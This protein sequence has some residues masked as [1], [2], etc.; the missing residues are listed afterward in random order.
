MTGPDFLLMLEEKR[1]RIIK[2]QESQNGGGLTVIIEQRAEK[3]TP[4]DS[5]N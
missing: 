1:L 2:P 5:G 3:K 4:P